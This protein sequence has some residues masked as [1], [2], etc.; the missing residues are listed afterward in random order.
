MEVLKSSSGGA[1]KHLKFR[2]DFLRLNDYS[3]VN[4]YLDLDV[5]QSVMNMSWQTPVV[6]THFLIGATDAKLLFPAV[7]AFFSIVNDLFCFPG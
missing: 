4:T 6:I 5:L 1:I 2:E 3:A 7:R